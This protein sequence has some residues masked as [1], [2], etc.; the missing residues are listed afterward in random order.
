[1]YG[2]EIL[3]LLGIGFE[4][5]AQTHQVR[6]DGARGWKVVVAP[7]VFEQ[8]IAA[9]GFSGVRDEVLEQFE[10][11]RGDVELPTGFDDAAAAKVN[12]DVTEGVMFLVFRGPPKHGEG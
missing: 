9:E 6:V 1:M 3:R 7:D 5:L 4:F 11:L 2:E 10:L 12:F 8:A